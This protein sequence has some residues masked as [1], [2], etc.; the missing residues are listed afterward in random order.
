MRLQRELKKLMLAIFSSV[1]ILG[2]AVNLKDYHMF[3]GLLDFS[4]KTLFAPL[5]FMTCIGLG[6]YLGGKY[7]KMETTPND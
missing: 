4:V 5:L 7:I 1:L 3:F 2:G 6:V